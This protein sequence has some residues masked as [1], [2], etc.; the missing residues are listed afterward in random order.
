[1]TGTDTVVVVV[2]IVFIFVTV[3]VVLTFAMYVG[4]IGSWSTWFKSLFEKYP[5]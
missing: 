2:V 4:F 1:M 5:L 3:V